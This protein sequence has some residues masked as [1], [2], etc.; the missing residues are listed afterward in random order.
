MAAFLCTLTLYFG[1][2]LH[3]RGPHLKLDPH[4]VFWKQGFKINDI[5]HIP[6]HLLQLLPQRQ[7]YQQTAEGVKAYLATIGRLDCRLARAS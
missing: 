3:G 6:P 4:A 5:Y 1:A 7:R 2:S